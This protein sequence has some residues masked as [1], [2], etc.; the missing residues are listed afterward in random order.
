[1][2]RVTVHGN[3]NWTLLSTFIKFP[4]SQQAEASSFISLMVS[5]FKVAIIAHLGA[6]ASEEA[7]CWM[8]GE[9]KSGL[10]NLVFFFLI[11]YF[12]HLFLQSFSDFCFINLWCSPPH[13]TSQQYQGPT[14]Q[15]YATLSQHWQCKGETDKVLMVP[16]HWKVSRG[17]KEGIDCGL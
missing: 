11:S 5:F 9:L 8:F 3:I 1:M 14:T 17:S 16:Q 6:R 12:P 4:V 15:A 7:L 10:V 13:P 2:W